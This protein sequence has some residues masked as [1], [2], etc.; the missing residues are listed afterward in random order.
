MIRWIQLI[1]IPMILVIISNKRSENMQEINNE[2]FVYIRNDYRNRQQDEVFW[3][4]AVAFLVL[5]AGLR[6]RFNDTTTYLNVFANNSLTPK[7]DVFLKNNSFALNTYWG[8]GLVKSFFKTI[9]MDNHLILLSY[10]SF[11]TIV[12]LWF[13]RKYGNSYLT[14]CMFVFLADGYLMLLAALKQSC[15]TACA[16]IAIDSLLNNKKL[17]YVVWM[18]VAISFHPYVFVLFIVL[19]IFGKKPWSIITWIMVSI[20]FFSGIYMERTAEFLEKYNDTYSAEILL[21]HSMNPIRFLVSFVPIIISFIYR[22]LLYKDTSKTE[23]LFANLS[24][25]RSLFYFWALFGNPIMFARVAN[26][27]DVFNA[28]FWGWCLHKL[29]N[30]LETRQIGLF[31]LKGFYI[32]F[33]LFSFY[34]CV[35]GFQFTRQTEHLH[36]HEL[37]QSISNWLGG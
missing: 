26:Y 1:F 13:I 31:L 36:L 19:F 6:I 22:N 27:F 16:L 4:L 7:I 25:I 3:F 15:A 32:G 37:M 17:K 30:T 2:S 8:Y 10:T 29:S 12:Y 34:S 9:G 14:I 11:Y 28:I 24:I 35:M 33:L 23:N 5:F 20:M 18:I 21:D